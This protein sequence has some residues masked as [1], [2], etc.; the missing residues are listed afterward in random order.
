MKNFKSKCACFAGRIGI[1]LC[2]IFITLGV[3]GVTAVGISK[4]N[5]DN[6]QV[7]GGDIGS[8][9]GMTTMTSTTTNANST[10]NMIIAFFSG[11]WGEVIL[12]LSFVSTI[13]GMWFSNSSKKLVPLSMLASIVIFVSMYVYYSIPL[14]IAGL[15]ILAFAYVSAFNYRIAKVAKLM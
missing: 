1:C 8:I 15:V 2:T 7:G 10:Q 13:V 11:F 14:E 4:N 3:I 6:M 12:L 9:S 5:N